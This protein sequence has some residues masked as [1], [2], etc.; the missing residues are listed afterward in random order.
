MNPVNH[1]INLEIVRCAY[2]PEYFIEMYLKINAR[3]NGLIEFK[4]LPYQRSII[5][6]LVSGTH[7]VVNK[8][9]QIGMSTILSAYSL[10]RA[11]F[12]SNVNMGI[13]NIDG[14]NSSYIM[15]NIQIMYDNLPFWLK[16]FC[17]MVPENKLRYKFNNG[18]KITS[19][20]SDK[21]PACGEPL[22]EVLV[23]ELACMTNPSEVVDAYS[24]TT[25]CLQIFSSTSYNGD[26]FNSIC[27]DAINGKSNR[28]YI[29]LDYKVSFDDNDLIKLNK[30]MSDRE[31]SMSFK[32][33]FVEKIL[34]KYLEKPY[35]FSKYF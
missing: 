20:N 16:H 28:T 25:K 26:T 14:I 4:L 22:S 15:K 29:K 31:I 34:K 12:C 2:D 24:H 23:D 1:A 18:N 35:N 11:L 17:I 19:L 30:G 7:I 21:T 13:I 27:R 9:R 6:L 8:A 10:W 3:S 32:C 5:K 33:I